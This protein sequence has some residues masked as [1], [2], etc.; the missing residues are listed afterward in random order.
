MRLMALVEAGDVPGVLR[1]L[2][3]LDAEQRAAQ[4]PELN[5]RYEEMGY[6]GWLE[7]TDEQ[8][9]AL[10]GARLGCQPTPDAAARHLHS[11]SRYVPTNDSW[12]VGVVELF[13][14]AWRTEL[15]ARLDER[16]R[17]RSGSQR[18][19][20]VVDHIVRTTG[21]PMPESGYF[22]QGWLNKHS[23]G[24]SSG[25]LERLREDPLTPTLLP[26]ALERSS[27]SLS[28]QAL[29]ALCVFAAEGMV[30]RAALVRRTFASAADQHPAAAIHYWQAVPL[31]ADEHARTAP[32]RAA[33]AELLLAGLLRDGAPKT[34]TP[35]VAFLRALALTPAEKAP[36]L[37]DHVAMLDLSSPVAS[38]GQEVLREL[39]EAGLLEEDVLSEACERVLLRS[40]K[41]LVRVQLSWL[42]RVARREPARVGRMLADAALAFGHPDV[43][44]QERALGLVARHLKNAGDPVRAELRRAAASLGPGLS[45]RAAEL[46][47][48]EAPGTEHD[49]G[50]VAEAEVLP[51][52]PGPLPVPGPVGTAAEVAQELAVV[53]TDDDV[54]AFE[55]ALDGLVRHAR[56][57]RAAL[58]RVLEP[59]MRREPGVH[60]DCG[61]S[62]GFPIGR[63][64]RDSFAPVLR[65][66][67]S[68]ASRPRSRSCTVPRR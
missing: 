43:S 41:K 42:D 60:R 18:L 33:L 54:V 4:L 53:L 66:A 1:A 27:I 26:L 16:V 35:V 15:V 28:T 23:Y 2:G 56:L 32:E 6:A 7:L 8:R 31:T 9:V 24:A 63:S 51:C 52:L 67:I 61:Q 36:F 13:P 48:T 59:V 5:A 38:Y 45:A 3:E 47:G 57:D 20:F 19:H 25:L 34:I 11:G 65:S 10:A 64:A 29:S 55:R 17:E 37:R 62:R 50:R 39:D 14:V 49:T 12:K 44:V 68:S 46:L 21:C 22:V 40:E 30:D 58:C